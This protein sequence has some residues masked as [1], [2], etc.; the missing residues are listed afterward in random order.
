MIFKAYHSLVFFSL[1]FIIFHIFPIALQQDD[2]YMMYKDEA[3]RA[4]NPAC[5]KEHF[6]GFCADLAK[7]VANHV[8][9]D[10]DICVVKDG[11]YG[12]LL[13]NKTWNGMIGELT[14]D[15]SERMRIECYLFWS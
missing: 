2:P 12:E 9:F 1:L 8:K 3:T 6:I 10:Y 15:V 7:E 4:L 13:M 11:L 14:R 5:G